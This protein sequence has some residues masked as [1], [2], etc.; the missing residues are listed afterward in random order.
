MGRVSHRAA[1]P[2]RPVAGS[3]TGGFLRLVPARPLHVGGPLGRR[4]RAAP[5]RA[6]RPLV[7]RAVLF[8]VLQDAEVTREPCAAL[9]ATAALFAAAA[10]LPNASSDLLL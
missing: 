7:V 10:A 2:P 9:A 3:H 1:A 8:V 6:V 4:P 5:L